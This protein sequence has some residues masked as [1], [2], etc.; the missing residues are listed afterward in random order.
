MNT[1]INNHMRYDSFMK[2]RE[3]RLKTLET[4][5]FKMSYVTCTYYIISTKLCITSKNPKPNS[6]PIP[7]PNHKCM[8]L[9]YHLK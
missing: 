8:L 9:I 2:S 7:K 1:K 4:L 3:T 6:N 5:Y